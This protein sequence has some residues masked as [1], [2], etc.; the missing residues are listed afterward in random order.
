MPEGK[1]IRISNRLYEHLKSMGGVMSKNLDKIVFGNSGWEDIKDREKRQLAEHISTSLGKDKLPL[2]KEKESLDVD[3]LLEA[4]STPD[5]AMLYSLILI[6]W[7]KSDSPYKDIAD[8]EA[9]RERGEILSSVKHNLDFLIQIKPVVKDIY[10]EF[11]F[12]MDAY[13]SKFETTMDNRITNLVR[14]KILRREDGKLWLNGKPNSEF[15]HNVWDY[16]FVNIMA[17]IKTRGFVQKIYS[18][19]ATTDNEAFPI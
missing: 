15:I 18:D 1:Q 7:T 3:K 4:A 12:E 16:Y 11:Y 9:P 5:S 2:A 6:A 14:A 8:W 19:P 13:R 10:P 17:N